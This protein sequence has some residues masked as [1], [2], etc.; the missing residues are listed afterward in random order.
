M[1]AEWPVLR[2]GLAGFSR[3]QEA[4]IAQGVA[5]LSG[6]LPW[7]IVPAA[8]ADALLLNG[9]R[10]RALDDGSLEIGCAEGGQA[11]RLDPRAA[12]LPLA[13]SLPFALSGYESADTFDLGAPFTL[14]R[15][16][17]KFEGWLRPQSLQFCLA[18]R[19]VQER[20]EIGPHV[21][22]VSVQ[23]RLIAVVSRR[24]GVAVL[25]IASPALVPQASWARR[26]ELAAETPAH[27]ERA[28]LA[29][30]LWRYALRSRRDLLPA[31]WRNGLL[32]WCRAPEVPH[33]LLRDGHLLVARELAQGPASLSQLERR[34]GLPPAQL[35]RDL[36]ALGLVGAVS[37]DRRRATSSPPGF[38]PRL[39]RGGRRG[40]ADHND[41]T[42]PMPLQG[43]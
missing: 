43:L 9:T 30:V 2:L 16:L 25:P 11:L 26:P 20:I 10:A 7:E 6:L 21:F 29:E 8:E 3:E 1:A 36:A 42:V 19:I 4:L 12:R 13:F 22:H 32:W 5:A 39:L 14:R 37:N 17:E 34:T 38:S 33:R 15:T 41:K 18:S 28:S 35:A 23:G 31:A 27:F 24:T 40:E